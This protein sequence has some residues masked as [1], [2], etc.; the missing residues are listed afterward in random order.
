MRAHTLCVYS[1][2]PQLPF[3]SPLISSRAPSSSSAPV[4]ASLHTRPCRRTTVAASLMI[5]QHSSYT[6]AALRPARRH[7]YSPPPMLITSP[8]GCMDQA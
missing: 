1:A 7:T 5:L 4:R 2:V 8:W 3:R 6:C